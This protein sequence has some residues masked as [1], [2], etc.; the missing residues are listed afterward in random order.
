M[1]TGKAVTRF[2]F[3]RALAGITRAGRDRVRLLDSDLAI[4]PYSV[5]AGSMTS[6]FTSELRLA[7]L[8]PAGNE[9]QDGNCRNGSGS[10]TRRVCPELC[11]GDGLSRRRVT[12]APGLS[13][14]RSRIA[15]FP[16]KPAPAPR[17][18]RR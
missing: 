15:R 3:S 6:L 4:I 11:A 18:A 17:G 10:H 5:W 9:Y 2:R 16:R 8:S 14:K 7:T 1:V 13:H 12:Y